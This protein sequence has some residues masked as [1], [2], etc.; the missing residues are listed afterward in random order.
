MPTH[1]YW[2]T[3]VHKKLHRN[4]III[5][6]MAFFHSFMVIVPVIVPFF[7]SKG[8]SLADI[9]YLQAVFAATIVVLEAPSGYFAD[10]FG[11]KTA[12][13]IGS[14]VH[15]CGYLLLNFADDFTSLIVFEITVAEAHRFRS[16]LRCVARSD[17]SGIV[18]LLLHRFAE[19]PFPVG[20]D[21]RPRQRGA[22]LFHAATSIASRSS[23]I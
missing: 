12:L 9:F 19:V 10:I 5:Y 1:G 3:I 21:D 11:R 8:L 17:R 15:G 22:F 13:L 14:V 18:R 20:V 4:I 2:G 7:M 16:K 23:A 6:G